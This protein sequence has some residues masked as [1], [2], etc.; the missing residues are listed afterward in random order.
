M[1]RR[2]RRRRF[3]RSQLHVP[4]PAADA[5]EANHRASFVTG[6]RKPDDGHSDLA[7][8]TTG[9]GLRSGSHARRPE[10]ADTASRP[11]PSRPAD[12]SR[13]IDPATADDRCCT[14][15]VT[16]C[17]RPCSA[18]PR[19]IRRYGRFS[20]ADSSRQRAHIAGRSGPPDRWPGRSS[21]SSRLTRS[22]STGP[23]H[24]AGDAGPG[25]SRK[26]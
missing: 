13:L 19:N 12:H 26:W 5:D 15:D 23:C 22:R 9:Q 16:P 6:I 25:R 18:V 4:G 3:S 10:A 21:R 24:D 7:G 8:F 11:Q 2:R 17:A 20:R 14:P 1:L